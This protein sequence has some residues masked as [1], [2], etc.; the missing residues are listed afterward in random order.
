MKPERML[1]IEIG[2]KEY[3]VQEAKTKEELLKGLSGV[4]S[5]PKDQGMLFYFGEPQEVS[6]WMKDTEIP[7]DIVFINEDLQVTKVHTGQPEDETLISQPD[8]MYVLEVNAD[9]G[10][11]EGDILEFDEDDEDAPVMWVLAQD[12][13]KQMPLWGGERIIS[14]RETK[15][16]VSKAKKIEEVKKDQ[17]LYEQK[18]KNLGK[19]VFKVFRGQ[20]NR[21]AEYVKS[22]K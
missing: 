7:L 9:S 15:V 8:T 14:R 11:K 3:S 4:T 12:Q 22:P 13:S 19:Y 16:I 1:D 6:M 2:G 5:L 21:P 18:C 10:I 20:D 17:K